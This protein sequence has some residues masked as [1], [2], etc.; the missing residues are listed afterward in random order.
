MATKIT[1]LG[2]RVLVKRIE[3]N[4]QKTDG[5]IFLP[6]TAKEKPQEAEVVALGTGKNDEGE[7]IEFSVKVGDKVLISKYGGTEVKVGGDEC[8]LVNESDILG[9]L[10]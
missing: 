9:I 7:I 8:V 6:D 4:E 10:S 5:G 1:P 3:L 2:T